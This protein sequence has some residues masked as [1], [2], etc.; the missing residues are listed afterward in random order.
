MRTTSGRDTPHSTIVLRDENE[1]LGLHPV[2]GGEALRM[3]GR[4][5]R[6]HCPRCGGGPV[7]KHWFK[8]RARC[9]NC[10]RAIERG[11][12]DY[13][14][15]SMMFNLVLAE[16]VF[17]AIFVGTLA[18]TWP[19]VPWTALQYAGPLGM[20]VAPFVL[21]PFSKL[22]WLAF[23]LMLR[24]DRDAAEQAERRR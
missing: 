16:L 1:D 4:A 11:E 6:L 5:L 20:L 21:F 24:P 18:V 12:S 7:L 8:M 15:G 2:R 14:I 10:G 22:V 13:F 19:D 3:F 17:T 9:G 23:D